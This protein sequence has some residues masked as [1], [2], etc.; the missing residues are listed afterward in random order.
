VSTSLV[1]VE[2][3]AKA[4]TIEK[5]LGDGYVV[6]ASIGHIRDLPNKVG[7]LPEKLRKEPGAEFGV[8]IE[9][10]MRPIYVVPTSKKA[11]VK[12]LKSL[13]KDADVLYLATD[14]D[15]EGEAIAWHIFDEIKKSKKPVFRVLFN[16]ITQRGVTQA[17]APTRLLRRFGF[18]HDGG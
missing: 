3:P 8:L 7:E 9:D 13:L 6:T 14:E 2:T 17:I 15:R 5:Y 18:S 10:G 4:K 12:E 11:Q 16:E 1:I